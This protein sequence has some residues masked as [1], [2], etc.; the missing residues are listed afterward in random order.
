MYDYE[1]ITPMDAIRE[2]GCTKLATRISE[3]I[4][5]GYS[6]EKQTVNSKNRYDQKVH[7]MRY[8]LAGFDEKRTEN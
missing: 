3:L 6:I 7:Y 1:W 4:N 8:R 5:N 2:F